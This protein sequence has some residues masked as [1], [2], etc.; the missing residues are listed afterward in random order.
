[1]RGVVTTIFKC[2]D[3]TKTPSSVSPK[4]TKQDIVGPNK[5]T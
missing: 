1:M 2:I 4:V 3:I 5:P